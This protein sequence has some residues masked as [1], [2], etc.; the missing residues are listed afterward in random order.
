MI[1]VALATAAR[2]PSGM[3]DTPALSAALAENGVAVQVRAWDDPEADWQQFALVVPHCTWDYLERQQEFRRWLL[4][5]DRRGALP[6]PLGLLDW[7]LD[8]A[9]LLELPPRG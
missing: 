4:A 8:K 3:A 5:C 9:Y 1:T 2:L 7:T 6:N